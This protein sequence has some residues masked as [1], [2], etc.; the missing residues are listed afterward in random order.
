MQASVW[1]LM[2]VDTQGA[3]LM[4][5][6]LVGWSPESGDITPDDLWCSAT[7]VDGDILNLLQDDAQSCTFS[8]SD[9]FQPGFAITM[10]FPVPVELWAA[11]FAGADRK[12]WPVQ[13]TLV[14]GDSVAR[15]GTPLWIGANLL[16]GVPMYSPKFGVPTDWTRTAIGANYSWQDCAMSA[17][18]Q[19][20]LAVVGGGPVW[21]T[22]DF[23]ATW[24]L[25]TDLGYRVWQSCAMSASGQVQLIAALGSELC[26]SKDGGLTWGLQ[27]VAG[28][29][30]W[31]GAA[32]SADGQTLLGAADSALLWLSKDGG[33]TW[34]E[35]ALPGALVWRSCGASEDGQTLVAVAAGAGA[36]W[37]SKDGGVSWSQASGAGARSWQSCAVSGDGQTIL[38]AYGV[39]TVILSKDGGDTWSSIRVADRSN[40]QKCS[41]SAS[42]Q[43]L[44][45]R[46]HGDHLWRSTDGGLNWLPLTDAGSRAWSASAMSA[47][48]QV[49]LAGNNADQLLLKAYL[50]PAY[51]LA[52]A[53]TK[54]ARVKHP[55]FVGGLSLQGAVG[56]RAH[57]AVRAADAENGGYGVVFGSVELYNQAG[58]IPLPRRVRL[59]RS[60]DGLLVRETWSDAQGNYRFEGISQRY[61]YDVIAWDHEGLQQSVVA[62]DLQ[63]EAM[64]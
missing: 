38:L 60:R 43:T 31:Y 2:G 19:L 7:P 51:A 1:T 45:L 35:Q 24:A 6:R 46:T 26:L 50:D 11:R 55:V 59:H 22:D 37:L 44:L 4:L 36:P 64:A 9:V 56:I 23:G 39:Q 30:S 32:V 49:L 62:N 58:N 25:D 34:A 17:S 42:G 10:Q 3:E 21:K 40:G 13:H 47:D 48:G 18:G 16:S 14:A 57:S 28:V 27:T 41:V 5:S 12:A 53:L 54:P 52:P 61:T 33:V 29:R 8:G 15:F 20:Q 63:P